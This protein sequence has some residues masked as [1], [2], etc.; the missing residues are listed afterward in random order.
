MRLCF[1][2]NMRLVEYQDKELAVAEETKQK[3]VIELEEEKKK[4][5]TVPP[6][7][8]ASSRSLQQ[9]S[10]ISGATKASA[11]VDKTVQFKAK[12]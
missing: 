6:T 8:A 4:A 10:A 5:S 9:S 1:L 11:L 3:L 7:N 12:L 2:F